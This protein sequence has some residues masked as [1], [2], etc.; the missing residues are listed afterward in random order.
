M[1]FRITCL[2][3][4]K[5]RHVLALENEKPIFY[6]VL[7]RYRALRARNPNKK[8]RKKRR[9]PRSRKLEK[10]IMKEERSYFPK[11]KNREGKYYYP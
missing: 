4:S 9:E 5:L 1:G 2:Y 7:E 8:S 6:K 3:I 10:R 11:P